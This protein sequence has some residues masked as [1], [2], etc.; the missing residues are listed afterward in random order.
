[1][2][3]EK[4]DKL[5]NAMEKLTESI[6]RIWQADQQTTKE[7]E[8]TKETEKTEKTE[9]TKE[10][11]TYEKLHALCL[12]LVRTDKNMQTKIKKLLKK[13]DARLIKDL[14]ESDLKP[15]K[16]ALMEIK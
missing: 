9:E 2:I 5:I 10:N 6:D 11:I 13:Y 8:E 14:K 12:K 3:E 1:M 4:I 16:T 7:T 15:F